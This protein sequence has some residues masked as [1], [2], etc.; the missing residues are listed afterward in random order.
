MTALR[1][2]QLA[3]ARGTQSA[4]S[5]YSP[6]A[7]VTAV[8][9]NVTVARTKPS[10]EGT[11]RIFIDD[12]GTDYNT[13]TAVIWDKTA[14]ASICLE[15]VWPLNNSAGNIALQTDASGS[16]IITVTLFGMEVIQDPLNE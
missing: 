4:T 14:S 1:E 7:N 2:K 10:V 3:Q 5:M 9:R 6:D 13:A 11:Y 15:V 12:N 8:I 16:G